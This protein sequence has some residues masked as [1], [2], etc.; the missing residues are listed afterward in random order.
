MAESGD[1]DG[2][3]VEESKLDA[4]PIIVSGR[5]EPAEDAALAAKA[6]KFK[7]VRADL[8]SAINNDRK[9]AG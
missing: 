8:V 3:E 5:G 6:L 4:P 9:Q 1:V 7:T 2:V